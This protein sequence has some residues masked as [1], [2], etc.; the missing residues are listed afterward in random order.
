MYQI[1]KVSEK[2]Q[3]LF[4]GKI[5]T[6]GKTFT[7]PPVATVVANLNLLYMCSVSGSNEAVLYLATIK[8]SFL[9]AKV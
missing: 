5:Y 3:T 1:S 6:F 7:R 8:T 2:N 4:S 9:S